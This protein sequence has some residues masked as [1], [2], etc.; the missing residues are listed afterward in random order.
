M[1]FFW[2]MELFKA[3]LVQKAW[4]VGC[5]AVL[6]LCFAESGRAGFCSAWLMLSDST[7][8]KG[9]YFFRKKKRVNAHSVGGK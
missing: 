3:I 2:P 7:K 4:P 8:S 5:A 1:I 6:W 9:V